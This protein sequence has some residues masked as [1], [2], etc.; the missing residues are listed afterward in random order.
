VEEILE[1]LGAAAGTD[2]VYSLVP[3]LAREVVEEELETEG[4]RCYRDVAKYLATEGKLTRLQV[5]VGEGFEALIASQKEL[6]KLTGS[7]QEQ[8][9]GL[10]EARSKL[11]VP[12]VEPTAEEQEDSESEL[13]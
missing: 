8:L 5:K 4:N 9:E 12:R 1:D 6:K 2:P 11:G 10:K 7:V 3:G 13:C